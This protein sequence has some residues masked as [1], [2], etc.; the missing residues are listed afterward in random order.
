MRTLTF[1]IFL[2]FI[3]SC[4][5]EDAYNPVLIEKNVNLETLLD[6]LNKPWGLAFLPDESLLITEKSGSILHY[7]NGISSNVNGVPNVISAGQGGL[8]DIFVHPIFEDNK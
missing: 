3:V 1:I 7:K 8:L 5:E 6:N 2:L 4:V